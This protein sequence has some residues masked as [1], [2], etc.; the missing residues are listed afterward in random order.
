MR[1]TAASRSSAEESAAAQ[2][3][4]IIRDEHGIPWIDGANTKVVEIVSHHQAYGETPEELHHALPHLSVAQIEAALAFYAE[5]R[6]EIEEDM[7]RRRRYVERLM[8]E[9]GQPPVVERI[10]RLRRERAA[11]REEGSRR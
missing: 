8:E 5:H 9:L 3:P 6:E 2:T 4:R 11:E 1:A 10:R 7:E